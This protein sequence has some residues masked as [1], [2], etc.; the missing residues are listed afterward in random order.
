MSGHGPSIITKRAKLRIR[1]LVVRVTRR[2]VHE[3]GLRPEV[4]QFQTRFRGPKESGDFYGKRLRYSF[5]TLSL[6]A[7][8]CIS[9]CNC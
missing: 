2:P 1:E 6:F 4:I 7:N 8:N 9:S 3:S 5:I